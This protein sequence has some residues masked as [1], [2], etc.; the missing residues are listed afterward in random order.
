LGFPSFSPKGWRVENLTT[1]CDGIVIW[2]EELFECVGIFGL[3]TK[4]DD[5]E[6]IGWGYK[7][8]NKGGDEVGITEDDEAEEDWL[9]AG[10]EF[11]T[12]VCG[13]RWSGGNNGLVSLSFL[14]SSLV[15]FNLSL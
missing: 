6:Y 13:C 8:K 5:C 3:T 4:L 10:K 15:I 12:V 9:F 1:L 11:V 14:L 2:A 7:F